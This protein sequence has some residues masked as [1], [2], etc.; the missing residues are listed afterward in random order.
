MD[1]HKA[2]NILLIEDNP[3]HAELTLRALK[4][5]NLLNDVFWVKDGE[6]ALE[7]LHRQGRYAEGARALR[8]GLILLDIKLP[9]IDGLEVLRSIKGDEELRSIPVV[10]LTT[11][12]RDDEVTECYRAG[13]NSFVT[14]PVRFA[15]F[16]ER[17]KRVKLYWMLT[18]SLPDC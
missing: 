16:V 8:P 14:K 9:K 3:D 13:V 15:E 6:E 18:N 12:A 1:R 10:M 7:F 4:D 11:S 2:V 5:G 17:V